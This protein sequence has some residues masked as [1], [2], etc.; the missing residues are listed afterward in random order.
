MNETI[1]PFWKCFDC[2]WVMKPLDLLKVD[3][4]FCPQCGSQS[5]ENYDPLNDKL[6]NPLD[7]WLNDNKVKS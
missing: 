1:V 7:R 4:A 5:L 6:V 2:K 3:D